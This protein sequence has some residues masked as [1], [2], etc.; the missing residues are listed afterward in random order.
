MYMHAAA[1]RAVS[2]AV[3]FFLHILTASATCEC[4][5]TINAAPSTSDQAFT[6]FT[7]VFETDFLHLYSLPTSTDSPSSKAVGWQPQVYNVSA[8][9]ARGPYG[10]SAQL[11][12]I[13]LNPL[14]T[15]W[16]W[17]G[18]GVNGG[19]PGLQ[20]WVDSIANLTSDGS[21]GQM[22][23][24]GEID[25]LRTDII[26]GSFRVGMKMSN[27]SGTC[28]AFF[29]YR[30]NTQEI[31]L[32]YLSREATQG[33]GSSLLNLVIQ[34][35]LSAELNYNAASTATYALHSLPF[36]PGDDY[37]EYRFDWTPTRISYY[38]DDV[39]LASFDQYDPDA[40]GSLMLNHWSNGDP[41]WSGGPPASDA[42]LTVSY[43]K[44]YFN[45]SNVTRTRQ[46]EGACA[47]S[48]SGR[49]CEIP[50]LPS[51][52][53]SPEG[54]DGNTTGKTFFFEYQADG[55]LVNQTVYPA[56]TAVPGSGVRLRSSVHLWL[57]LLLPWTI[58]LCIPVWGV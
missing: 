20:V 17:G 31:D 36:L 48:W 34:S 19:S 42:V 23:R 54:A 8:A 5:Y 57:M 14:A 22:I 24:I 12:N 32:E 1:A 16:D 7:E 58:V 41:K 52:G 35:P 11:E 51:Q 9:N 3:A 47:N 40:P 56:A 15:R 26:Y 10:K 28:A 39:F 2:T 37:H 55:A 18:E 6:L 44:A 29:W 4:G 49:T 43:I 45:T 53:I 13:I 38:A 46:W 33:N 25:S 30:N 21:G 27:V 50:Q